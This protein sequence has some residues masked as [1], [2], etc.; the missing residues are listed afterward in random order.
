MPIKATPSLEA[1]YQALAECLS[2]P[3]DW[4]AQAGR[5]WPLYQAALQL[6]NECTHSPLQKAVTELALIPSEG[7]KQWRT[8][9]QALLR[10]DAQPLPIYK[11]LAREGRLHSAV[12]LRVWSLYQAAGLAVNGAELPDHAAIE[13]A[14][15]A[16]LTQQ[17]LQTQNARH[18]WRMARL[19]FVKQHAGQWLPALGRAIACS[20][21]GFYRPIGLL[22]S[23]VLQAE[24]SPS[25]KRSA[26]AE[27]R[28]PRIADEQNCTLCSFCA[29]VCPTQAISVQETH[30]FTSLLV[31]DANCVGC[32]R[33]VGVCPT[34]TLQLSVSSPEPR[35]RMLYRSER[36]HCPGC[37]SPTVSQAE[38]QAI[39]E[40]IGNPRWL[41]YC[42]D[43]RIIFTKELQ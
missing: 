37:G 38:L 9:Y 1:V 4:L 31:N 8:R 18:L 28:L 27:R 13:L 42:C 15:L 6:A 33:C 36:A 20:S 17:E 23:A 21:D 16:Y 29:Q 19:K 11:S 12:T 3:C 35:P 34:S 24:L 5:Q 39:A 14:F 40:Q 10:S 30:E 7:L 41:D 43:C 22:L 26:T 25:R 2:E 32:N